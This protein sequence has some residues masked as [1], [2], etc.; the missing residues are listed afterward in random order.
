MIDGASAQERKELGQKNF[1]IIHEE[2]FFLIS[3]RK[4]SEVIAMTEVITDINPNQLQAIKSAIIRIDENNKIPAY[5]THYAY[6]CDALGI[7]PAR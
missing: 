2:L 6:F 3:K 4:T 5:K 1:E 7:D